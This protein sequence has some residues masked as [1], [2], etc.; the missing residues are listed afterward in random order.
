PYLEE[1]M[2]PVDKA[3]WKALHTVLL[4]FKEKVED[5]GLKFAWHNHEF[6][7]M[8]F[9]DGSYGIEYLLGEDIDF[10]ADIGWIYLAGEDPAKWLG[11]YQGRVPAVHVKDVAPAGEAVAE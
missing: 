4:G 7:F 3:G 6:E 8:R 5:A 2:R 9:D 11:H 1:A 10:A